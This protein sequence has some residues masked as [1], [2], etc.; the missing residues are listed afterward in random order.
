MTSTT[1]FLSMFALLYSSLF[2]DSGHAFSLSSTSTTTST[3][4][5]TN[6]PLY[7]SVDLKNLPGSTPPFS[8]GFD[9]LRL[10]T[11]GSD[12]TLAWFQAAYVHVY[13]SR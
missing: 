6:S 2:W 4:R 1:V 3:R 10:S 5:T 8:N 13:M 7:A 12:A 11:V 9:P